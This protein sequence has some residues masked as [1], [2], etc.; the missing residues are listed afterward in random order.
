[1]TNLKGQKEAIWQSPE[2]IPDAPANY[3]FTY[4]GL[5]LNHITPQMSGIIA[6]TDSRFRHDQRFF[7]EGKVQDAEKEKVRLEVKQRTAR[8][9]AEKNNEPASPLFFAKTE[10]KNMLTGKM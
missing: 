6:P 3:N 7:E 1:L 8:Q 5:L 10:I 2:P 9:E 4:Q